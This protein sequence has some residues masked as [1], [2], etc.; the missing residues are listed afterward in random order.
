MTAD[1]TIVIKGTA[2][3]DTNG[4]LTPADISKTIEFCSE[5]HR[6]VRPE[7]SDAL[8]A[9]IKNYG[10]NSQAGSDI[11]QQVINETEKTLTLEELQAL[12]VYKIGEWCE[13]MLTILTS[14]LLAM[15]MDCHLIWLLENL[16]LKEHRLY[17]TMQN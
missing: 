7:E 15:S 4:R 6:H 16:I 14:S 3:A 9:K 10:F 17:S 1:L 5:A 11:T 13:K 8:I 2:G 12:N